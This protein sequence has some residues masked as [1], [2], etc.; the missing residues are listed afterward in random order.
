MTSDE[1]AAGHSK[2]A[3]KARGFAYNAVRRQIQLPHTPLKAHEIHRIVLSIDKDGNAEAELD[4]KSVFK[5]PAPK[6]AK[7]EGHVFLDGGR[8]DVVYTRVAIRAN[9]VA[10]R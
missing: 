3:T 1:A 10:P 4:G 5:A 9:K 8:G 2:G 7:L 6:D